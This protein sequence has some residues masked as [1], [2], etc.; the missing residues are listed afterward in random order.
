MK[1]PAD[2][3]QDDDG[4]VFNVCPQGGCLEDKRFI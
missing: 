2:K 1:K 3:V 4:G